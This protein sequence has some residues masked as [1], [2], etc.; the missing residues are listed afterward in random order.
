[1][2]LLYRGA[3]EAVSAAR[4]HLAAGEIRD[5]SR[6]ITRCWE[7]LHELRLSLN[8]ELGGELSRSLR[9]LYVYAQG[10]LID[11]NA[12]QADGPLAEVEQILTTL[13]EGWSSIDSAP[14]HVPEN[15]EP[16]S[17]PC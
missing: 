8:D 15:Y 1:M 13:H 16:L 6:K 17:C 7:I 2:N 14:V 5:R 9:A 4:R 10:R 3:I 11:G 12:Q